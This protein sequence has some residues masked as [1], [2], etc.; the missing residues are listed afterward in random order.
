ME[1]EKNKTLSEEETQKLKKNALEVLSV[2]RRNLL[3]SYPF[4]GSIALRMEIVPIRDF[5]IKTACTDG[6]SVYFDIAFLSELDRDEQTFVF[7]HEVWHAVLMHLVRRHDRDLALFNIATDKEVN[8]MLSQDGFIPPK[9]LL[10]PTP[11]EEGKCAEEIYEMLLKKQKNG[12]KTSSGKGFGGD[13]VPR[14]SKPEEDSDGEDSS[15][16]NKGKPEKKM[17]GQFDKHVYSGETS[18]DDELSEEEKKKLL[19]KAFSDKYGEVSVDPD[20]KPLVAKNFSDKMRQT[21]LSE[22][23]RAAKMRGT[24]PAHIKELVDKITEPE[25]KWTEVL[26]QFVTRCYGGCSRS[27]IPP[28]RRHVHNGLYLPSCHGEKMKI[29]VG[30]DTSGSTLDDRSKFLGELCGLVRSFGDFEL[31]VIECDAEV[32]SCEHYTQDDDLDMI[33]KGGEYQMTGGGG[34][35]MRPIFEH[36][37]KNQIDVDAV[38]IMTDG[39]IDSIPTNPIPSLPVLWVITKN[40][41]DADI[42][43]GKTIKLKE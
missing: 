35:S 26:A 24:L 28:N 14:S 23:Q 29:A 25:I 13:S 10:F 32:G 33:I 16:S 27:W 12:K 39:Y 37:A 36:I 20:F 41:T 15:T 1:K 40:G 5:R 34:T 43:F 8:Y 2:C 22:A 42:H 19:D 4:I 30:I 17:S 18:K 6:S 9:D 21:I 11:E 31:Y 3:A 38:C 7:A